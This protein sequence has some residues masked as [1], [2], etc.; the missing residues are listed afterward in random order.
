MYLFFIL[1]EQEDMA[2]VF[3]ELFCNGEIRQVSTI[4]GIHTL[5]FVGNCFL[6]TMHRILQKEMEAK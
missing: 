3:T 6:V 5:A 1:E 4:K 2:S